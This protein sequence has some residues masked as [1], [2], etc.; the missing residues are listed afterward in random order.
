[1]VHRKTSL[2]EELKRQHGNAMEN[3]EDFG[4]FLNA[5]QALVDKSDG[6]EVSEK[7]VFSNF[8]EYAADAVMRFLETKQPSASDG[9]IAT[10]RAHD[11]AAITTATDGIICHVN[12]KAQTEEKLFVGKH[13]SD[14]GI[15]FAGD[16][17]LSDLLPRRATNGSQEF[18]LIQ[19]RN[20]HLETSLTLA[21]SPI[22]LPD[23]ADG[24]FIILFI[25]PPDTSLAISMLRSK[26]GL[27]AVESEIAKTFLDGSG[28]RDIARIRK[29]SYAT[30]RNQFQSILEKTGCLSQTEFFRLAFSLSH[31]AEKPR[32]TPLPDGVQQ[33]SLPRPKGRTVEVV[34][35]GDTAGRPLLSFCSLFGHGI[36]PAIQRILIS[37]GVFLISVTR[38]GFGTT[39]H[40]PN[41][42][43][44]SDCL[45]GDV[46]A[47]LDS[48]EI[49]A[50]PAIARASAARSFFD[51]LIQL[52]DRISNGVVVNG[53]V[54]RNFISNK[55]VASKWTTA[56]MS[57]TFVSRPIAKL[58]LA[59]G[60]SLFRRSE[61]A[62]F[63]QKMYQN[64]AVDCAVFD[65]P[66]VVN[67]VREGV[68]CITHQGLSAGAQEMSD[69]FQNWSD[70]L[71]DLKTPVTLFHG[72]F[73]PNIPIEAVQ[74]F[75]ASYPDYIT[76]EESAS[77][78]GQLHYSHFDQVLELALD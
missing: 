58:I 48:L 52:P 3:V 72:R 25:S 30:I 22:Q 60:N 21:I 45:A 62:T 42:Q 5:W 69:A 15:V 46:R 17:D 2:E 26:F 9:M 16:E 4:A 36:T 29:R 43:S 70:D 68:D 77:G 41:G 34:L 76:L 24:Q 11:C 78:G 37:K 27:T 54:P 18:L 35:S 75:A 53:T 64:S 8:E 50:C 7:A 51:L 31:L 23:M 33:L 57:A 66:D 12:L 39:S 19:A 74:E 47:I 38:P 67:S 1:M 73:D 55:T 14:C 49:E 61:G 59:T 28:L 65:D 13:L 40:A 63:L 56:L 32:D 71:R 10:L 20:T 44:L 6:I